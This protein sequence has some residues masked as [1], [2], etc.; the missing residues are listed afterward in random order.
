MRNKHNRVTHANASRGFLCFPR[1]LLSTVLRCVNCTVR[2]RGHVA[3]QT[4]QLR[5]W[6]VRSA[7][8]D[9]ASVVNEPCNFL[10]ALFICDKDAGMQ[11]QLPF[12]YEPFFFRLFFYSNGSQCR[13][14]SMVVKFIDNISISMEG[15]QT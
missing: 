5:H 13:F 3:A 12:S 7:T 15:H 11:Q 6:E 2:Y 10:V 14:T 8:H 1:S 9:L 4:A